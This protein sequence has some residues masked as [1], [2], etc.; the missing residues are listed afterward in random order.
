MLQ[1][2]SHHVI[3]KSGDWFQKVWYGAPESQLARLLIKLSMPFQVQG[4]THWYTDF[5]SYLS[6]HKIRDVADFTLRVT[7]IIIYLHTKMQLA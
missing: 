6:F 7:Y 1:L 2:V 3:K 4:Y 5:L